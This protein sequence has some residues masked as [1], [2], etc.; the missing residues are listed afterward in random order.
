MNNLNDSSHVELESDQDYR[1]EALT[2]YTEC[3]A[4]WREINFNYVNFSFKKQYSHLEKIF[5]P[6]TTMEYPK[7]FKG[8]LADTFSIIMKQERPSVLIDGSN[9]FYPA[10][11]RILQQEFQKKSKRVRL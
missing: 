9:L 10:F 1:K 6:I 5:D 4:Y 11:K 7:A 2:T 3:I 8:L